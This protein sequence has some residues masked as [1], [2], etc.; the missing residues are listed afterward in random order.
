MRTKKAN[1]S[2]DIFHIG[3]EIG[4]ILKGLNGILEILGGLS[5]LFIGHSRLNHWLEILT[6]YVT[7]YEL[8]EDP[9]DYFANLLLKFS[10]GFSIN[11]HNF[12]IFYLMSHG[13]IKCILVYLLWRRKL[14]AYPLTIVALILFIAYQLY[15][16]VISPSDFL[17]YLTILDIIMIFLTYKEYQR[18]K[19]MFILNK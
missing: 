13:I 5:L 8:S 1:K 6:N 19:P 3:F 10:Q 2:I 17:I 16:Y 9:D 4:I 15:R 12:F 7:K 18:I 11:T 14:W